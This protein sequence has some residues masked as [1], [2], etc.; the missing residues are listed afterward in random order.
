MNSSATADAGSPTLPPL[1]LAKIVQ[2][3]LA[4]AME[5]F[6]S[7]FGQRLLAIETRVL[8]LKNK[9]GALEAKVTD[10]ASTLDKVGSHVMNMTT[11]EALQI[12]PSDIVTSKEL[13]AVSNKS[14]R[15]RFKLMIMNNT[16]D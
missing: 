6:K 14:E 16:V 7:E 15:L 12:L 10:I 9:S 1:E 8:F 13:D 11:T 2:K 3:A 5:V 4:A